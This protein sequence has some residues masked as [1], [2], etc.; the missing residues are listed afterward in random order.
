MDEKSGHG[1]ADRKMTTQVWW[2]SPVY[3]FHH[4]RSRLF[5]NISTLF[6]IW[7]L[8]RDELAADWV[9]LPRQVQ[10]RLSHH[11]CESRRR[12][13]HARKERKKNALITTK[14]S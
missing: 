9:G 2:L 7:K 1:G 10:D 5:Q 14:H 4:G 12:H 3:H 6:R 11:L 13:L 8:V